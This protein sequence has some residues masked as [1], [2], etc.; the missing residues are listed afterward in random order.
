MKGKETVWR[1]T[2]E[3]ITAIYDELAMLPPEDTWLAR[4]TANLARANGYVV[5]LCWDDEVIDNPYGL[6]V[7]LSHEQSF[8]WFWRAATMTERIEWVLEH[9]LTV[10]RKYQ[11]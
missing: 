4:R 7:G 5:P 11:W 1:E 9:G 2:A 6:P 8:N 10:T 3:K